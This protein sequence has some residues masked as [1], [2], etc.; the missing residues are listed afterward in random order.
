MTVLLFVDV[1]TT[2]LDPKVD[3]LLEVSLHATD[4]QLTPL[5]SGLHIVLHDDGSVDDTISSMHSPNGLLLECRQATITLPQ[6]ELLVR[7]YCKRFDHILLAGSTVGFDR[8]FLDEKFHQV[9][10]GANFSHRALDISAI[11]EAMKAWNPDML[12]YRPKKTTNH[13]TER[14]LADTLRLA[15]FYQQALATL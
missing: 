13:R 3:R 4:E 11:D 14:C 12:Q 8:A 1:E 15:K 6:T 2:G 9:T 7:N 10:R 5:D